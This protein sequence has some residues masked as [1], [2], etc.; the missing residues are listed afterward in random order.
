VQTTLFELLP[1]LKWRPRD[2]AGLSPGASEHALGGLRGSLRARAAERAR[3]SLRSD[4]DALARFRERPGLG[5]SDCLIL[6]TARKAGHLALG[7]FDRG[8]AKLEG[9]ERLGK[10]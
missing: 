2:H 5:F 9:A 7:T 4:V 8:L 10:R 6:E 3:S 1:E